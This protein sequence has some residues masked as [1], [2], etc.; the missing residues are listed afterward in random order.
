MIL[1]K[2]TTTFTAASS[3]GSL[4]VTAPSG[5]SIGA[6]MITTGGQSYA[7]PVTL[8][9]AGLFQSTAGGLIT[10]GSTVNGA[11]NMTVESDGQIALDTLGSTTALK[12]LTTEGN[13]TAATGG[14]IITGGDAVQ[15]ITLAN[16]TAGTFTL[17]FNGQT[18]SPLGFN[19]TALQVQTALANLSNIGVGQINVI[20]LTSVYV[21][22]FGGTLANASQPIMT[23]ASS[24]T[25]NGPT[26]HHRFHGPAVSSTVTT[27]GDRPS[28][29]CRCCIPM[30]PW[31][32]PI[33]RRRA[34]SVSARPSTAWWETSRACRRAHRYDH[35]QQRGRW[36]ARHC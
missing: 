10:F 6:S 36:R 19:P 31:R 1:A 14:T 18:T 11:Q 34:I 8:T 28:K 16:A 35:L 9:A 5:I 21:V 3:L 22:I 29:M 26:D 25:G 15:T 17:T 20:H 2:T 27:S 33:R 13:S 7:N 32:A 24:L 12:S 23:A 30:L 4:A